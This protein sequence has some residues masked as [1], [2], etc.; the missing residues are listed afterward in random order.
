MVLGIDRVAGRVMCAGL[1]SRGRPKPQTEEA[2]DV[3]NPCNFRAAR[4]SLNPKLLT[5]HPVSQTLNHEPS[6]TRS[7]TGARPRRFRCRESRSALSSLSPALCLC[8]PTL[9][10]GRSLG[11]GGSGWGDRGTSFIRNCPP[12]P[13]TTVGLTRRFEEG[14]GRS[15][16]G[17]SPA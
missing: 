14:G 10:G 2:L 8:P 17:A 5:R 4:S 11:G 6:S 9:L 7:R 16:L 1:G 12:P 15:I 13:R 3:W